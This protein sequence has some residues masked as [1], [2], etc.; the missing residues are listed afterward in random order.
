MG[1]DGGQGVEDQIEGCKFGAQVCLKYNAWRGTN[2][3]WFAPSGPLRAV[4]PQ[5]AEVTE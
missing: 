2:E 3:N 5:V 1:G 4:R